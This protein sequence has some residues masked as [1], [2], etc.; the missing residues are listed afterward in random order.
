MA[1]G[2]FPRTTDPKR[3]RAAQLSWLTQCY[4]DISIAVARPNNTFEV[5]QQYGRVVE[6]W[7]KYETAHSLYINEPNLTEHER[8]RLERQHEKNNAD[9]RS[10]IDILNTYLTI[11]SRRSSHLTSRANSKEGTPYGAGAGDNQPAS[12]FDVS[13]AREQEANELLEL[14]RLETAKQ[15]QQQRLEIAG[16]RRSLT[17]A[18]SSQSKTQVFDNHQR[19][20][21]DTASYYQASPYNQPQPHKSLRYDHT[22][23]MSPPGSNR[24]GLLTSGPVEGRRLSIA[25]QASDDGEEQRHQLAVPLRDLSGEDWIRAWKRELMRLPY[26]SESA[27][28]EY[29]PDVVL[30]ELPQSPRIENNLNTTALKDVNSHEI[31]EDWLLPPAPIR[32]PGYDLQGQP[33]YALEPEMSEIGRAHV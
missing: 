3:A 32:N 7:H 14:Q 29:R 11:E 1:E 13:R 6:Q 23:S 31:E 21:I 17:E 30:E 4:R 27:D 16:L 15:F 26:V 20:Q 24:H 8:E 9:F 28:E 19:E 5:T 25:S 22:R 10:N 18:M 33:N 2:S 12:E